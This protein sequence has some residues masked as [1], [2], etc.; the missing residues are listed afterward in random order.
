MCGR[1]TL[2]TPFQQIQE[3]FDAV[4]PD[5]YHKPHYNIAP[6]QRIPVLGMND[7]S[8]FELM[9]WGLV[10]HWAKDPKIGYKMINARGETVAEKPS[11]R[12]PFK[13][14]RC[15]IPS[16]GF[17]EWDKISGTRTPYHIRL[18]DRT[19]FSYA[20]LCDIWKDPEGKEMQTF[21]I[22]TTKSNDLVGKI[23]D[24]MPVILEEDDESIWMSK[25]TSPHQLLDLIRPYD[26][27][28][29]SITPLST[30]VNNPKNDSEAVLKPATSGE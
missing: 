23:H 1:F 20:G 24:R 11:F 4:L 30:L 28:T 21:S 14:R 12:V 17:Y 5:A 3:R 7:Q 2:T 27:D 18:K 10:P 6:G 9:K 16:D 13:R 19:L 29:M 8:T 15:L 25:K 26:A 22:I